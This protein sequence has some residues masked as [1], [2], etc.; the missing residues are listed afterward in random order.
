MP[1]KTKLID[2]EKTSLAPKGL[3]SSGEK[4]FSVYMPALFRRNVPLIFAVLLLSCAC[5]ILPD[6]RLSLLAKYLCFAIAALGVDLIWG[7]G[8]ML[9][10]GQGIFFGLG[11]YAIAM[12][13]KLEASGQQ[14]PDFMSWS[15]LEKLP[16][17]WQPF[18]NPVFAICM[19]LIIPM[20]LAT[21]LGLLLFRNRIQG[22]YFSII[23]Q[24]LA[25]ILVTLLIGQQA[26][27][28]GTNGIT[29]FKTIFGFTLS[30]PS[31][32]RTLFLITVVCLAG[33]YLL[34]RRL[35]DSRYGRLL[36]ALREDE[37]RVRC[38]GYDPVPLKTFAFAIS[39]GLAGLAGA[40]FVLQVG[41]ISPSNMG[42]V[43]S[44]EMVIWVA[45]GGRGTLIGAIIGAL[46]VNFGK[47]TFSELFPEAWP[48]FY[49]LL[50]AA[51]L[52]F[53]SGIVGFIKLC[54][55]KLSA[56]LL[57]IKNNLLAVKHD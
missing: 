2:S 28:G 13:L 46:L 44:A 56:N 17:F 12:Y 55:N 43:P 31:V 25:L 35:L 30:D 32:Q 36:V 27:T 57:T 22:V 26:I 8:G 6:F 14:L 51:V 21:V 37:N 5:L 41:L 15:G 7:Y 16:F 39:A 3:D 20:A 24:A 48:Y 10:L 29:N 33:S 53:P 23:T 42:I 40:L 45:V 18:H 49:G 19:V 47:T 38:L 11:A 9:C 34:C 50:I 52:F 4:R 54:A 1:V